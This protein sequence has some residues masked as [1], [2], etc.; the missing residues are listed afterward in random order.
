MGT[1][2][3]GNPAAEVRP[4]AQVGHEQLMALLDHTSAVIYMRDADGRYM[5][6]NREYER[7]FQLRRE[8]IVGLTDHDLFPKDTA[9]A[10]RAND[11]QAF[12]RGVPVQMEEEVPGDGEVRTYITVKFPL[13]DATGHP[14]AVCGISTDI[15]DRKR[16]EE[17]VRQLNANLELR[18]RERTAE[19]EASTRELDAFAYSVS[20]DLRAPLRSLEGFS[21][22]LQEDYADVLD[23][24]GQQY[25]R[26]IQANVGRMAQMIDDLL[27]LS[28]ATRTE[29]H[30]EHTDLSALAREVIAELRNADPG[31]EVEV[32]V[33]EGLVAQADPHLIR[34]V[35][36]NLLGNAWK[37][38][39]NRA[40][41]TIT[42]DSAPCH[43]IEVFAVT[44]NGAGFDMRYSHKLFDP[45]QRLHS[46][47]E[48]EGTGIGLAIVQRIITR[49]GGQIVADSSPGNGATFRFSLTPAPGD[50]EI[51]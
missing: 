34:L 19:L 17:Q 43:G 12:A 38:T 47:A 10:F 21:Q 41:A 15:T 25:L 46:A 30:R 26:R 45:F 14:Y 16:A 23:E 20:H 48:Y 33:A 11:L 50:W 1:K 49:H 5:L 29:L 32:G 9:D 37:F 7:L 36:Q 3:N 24:Q 31:R 42:M 6:V 2:V 39:A 51:R 8:N 35:L 28:R 40:D 13:I 44:D 4:P 22:V 27:G 18:V